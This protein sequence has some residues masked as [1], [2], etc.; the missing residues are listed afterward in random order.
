MPLGCHF[1]GYL[2][3]YLLLIETVR[4][5]EVFEIISGLRGVY[6]LIRRVKADI[7]EKIKE[8]HLSARWCGNVYKSVIFS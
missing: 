4:N 8:T 7:D 3:K 5:T 1:K 2:L 6:N